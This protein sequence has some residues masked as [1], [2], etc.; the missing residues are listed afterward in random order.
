MDGPT[1]PSAAA[2]GDGECPLD[3]LAILIGE[4]GLLL[5]GLASIVYYLV[6]VLATPGSLRSPPL[7][8]FL[9]AASGSLA[10]L[11]TVVVHV[12]TPQWYAGRFSDCFVSDNAIHL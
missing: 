1:K 3:E 2:V 10:G 6:W 4:A 5:I 8:P 9:L 12:A 7:S 11:C